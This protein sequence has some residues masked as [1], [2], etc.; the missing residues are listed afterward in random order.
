VRDHTLD[1]QALELQVAL[2]AAEET[3]RGKDGKDDEKEQQ[4]VREVAARTVKTLAPLLIVDAERN[5]WIVTA[6]SSADTDEWKRTEKHLE[7]V[8]ILLMSAC[9][10]T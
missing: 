4:Q 1:Q 7:Q 2:S 10:Q 3:L 8:E 5:G 9:Y 6:L